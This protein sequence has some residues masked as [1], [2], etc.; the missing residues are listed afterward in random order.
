MLDETG[1]VAA[2]TPTGRGRYITGDILLRSM[3]RRKLLPEIMATKF[4]AP[5]TPSSVGGRQECDTVGRWIY[6]LLHGL[7]CAQTN[8]H[9]E[10]F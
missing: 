4:I 1:F 5:G 6:I 8:E 7:T 3:F 2:M 10:G 9:A